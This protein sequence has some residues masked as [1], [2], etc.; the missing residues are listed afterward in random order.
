[1]WRGSWVSR[2]V[3]LVQDTVWFVL[4][5]MFAPAMDRVSF[6][7]FVETESSVVASQP[8]RVSKVGTSGRESFSVHFSCNKHSYGATFQYCRNGLPQN[9][10]PAWLSAEHFDMPWCFYT[11]GTGPGSTWSTAWA[12]W[13]PGQ[14]N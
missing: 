12:T 13:D 7:S 9:S 2:I 8:E 11:K 6:S 1:M 5:L 10:D 4:T 3:T 14:Q